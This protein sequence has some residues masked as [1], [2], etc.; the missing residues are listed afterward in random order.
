MSRNRAAR[1]A[2]VVEMAE[3]AE[4][5]AARMLGRCQAQVTQAEMKLGELERYRSDYQQQWIEEGRRGVSGQWLMNYQ[6]FLSQLESAIGQQLQ[7]V[8]WHRENLDKARAAWQQRYARLEGLRKLVQ[9]YLDEARAAE[10]KREQKLLD[11]LVQRLPARG[12][13]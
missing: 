9:R 13:E 4:R 8:K 12:E 10:D 6:R 7:S 2:P 3:R 5:E 1:L 11:E